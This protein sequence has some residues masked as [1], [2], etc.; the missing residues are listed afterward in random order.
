MLFATSNGDLAVAIDFETANE[1]RTSACSIGVAWIENG[2]VTATEEHLI[3]PREMRFNPFNS[4]IH[5]IRADDVADAPEFPA[6]WARLRE[7]LD[8][9]LILA[10]N[11][12]FDLSVLRHTLTDYGLAWPVCP[13]LCTVTLARRAW[14]TLTAHKLNHL[15]DFL[16]IALEHHR[17]GSDAEACG[18]IALAATQELG[19][20]RLAAIPKGAGIT[21]GQLTPDGYT[22]CK[23]AKTPPRRTKVAAQG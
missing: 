23:G 18:R 17:A 3:R 8:G 1:S 9:R 16:G 19:L 12:A 4:T 11:A 5:G 15:A 10:H 7:R 21:F 6:V 20:D 2:R 22:A 13:Y 14:P